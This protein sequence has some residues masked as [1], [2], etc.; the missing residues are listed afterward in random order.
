M[1]VTAMN[2]EQTCSC[3]EVHCLKPTSAGCCDF[4]KRLY[5]RELPAGN[6]DAVRSAA[7]T[8]VVIAE[9]FAKIT[10]NEAPLRPTAGN[11][12]QPET[13]HRFLRLLRRVCRTV[14]IG[15]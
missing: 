8:V 14:V 15:G 7:A 11:H 5:H 3:D 6:V 10:V 2:S 1:T 9:A 12:T 4:L 13:V